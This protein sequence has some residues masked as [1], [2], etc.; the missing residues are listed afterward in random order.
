MQCQHLI[1]EFQFRCWLCCFSIRLASA[2]LR[3]A[4]YHGSDIWAWATNV[5]NQDEFPSSWLQSGL[6]F[7]VASS[8]SK[9]SFFFCLHLSCLSIC[10]LSS[11]FLSTPIYVHVIHIYI[12]YICVCMYIYVAKERERSMNDC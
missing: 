4:V 9:I 3:K 6:D 12:I 8:N 7:A 11:I 2:L 10:Y 5:G 1:L